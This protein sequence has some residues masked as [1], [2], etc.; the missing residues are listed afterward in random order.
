MADEM[1]KISAQVI[2]A[3]EWNVPYPV[4]LLMASEEKIVSTEMT[5]LFFN[6]VAAKKKELFVFPGFYHEIF[7]EIDRRKFYDKMD[8]ILHEIG[9]T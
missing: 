6:K 1:I 7:R 4:Y 8:Q 5:K 2:A 9:N 3:R